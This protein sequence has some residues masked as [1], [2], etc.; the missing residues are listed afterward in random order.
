MS[1]VRTL[2]IDDDFMV[3]RVHRAYTE[4]VP[5]FEVVG[6]AH[7]GLEA[8]EAVE[9]LR[10]DLIVLDIYLPDV[11]GL[12][13]LQELRRRRTAVDAIMVTAAK[14]VESLRG[15][16]ASVFTAHCLHDALPL[17]DHPDLS[18]AVLDFGLSD[19]DAGGLCERLSVRSIP[20]V[21]YSGYQHGH[22]GCRNGV[23][24]A[25]PASSAEL[26]GAVARLLQ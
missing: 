24:L 8:L 10:P 11:S 22:A 14:D 16:G 17:A 2:I 4:R 7:S 5:G 21:L 15:A 19:G 25:K 9:R 6:V 18:A 13:V 23:H 26:I 3:A 12:E 1:A 20:F